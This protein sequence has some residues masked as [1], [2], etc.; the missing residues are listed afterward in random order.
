MNTKAS[1]LASKINSISAKFDQAEAICADDVSDF[2]EEKTQEVILHKE[3]YNPVD[4][5]T[6]TQMADDFK[7]C[8]ETLRETIDN[9][10]RVLSVATSD[11]LDADD[12]SKASSVL[13]FAELN[14]AVMNGIKIQSQLYKD[15]SSV[16]IN[17]KKLDEKSNV[18]N[19]L[20]NNVTVTESVNTVELI[21]KLRGD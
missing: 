7:Y 19:N 10:R 9:G 11:L 18:T 20:T 8:R 13:A 5:I 12:D 14:T 21:K 17:I 4:V 6:L 2:V 3:D 16:L 15:F 1:K